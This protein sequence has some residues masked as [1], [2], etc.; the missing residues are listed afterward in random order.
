MRNGNEDQSHP[1][2]HLPEDSEPTYEEWKQLH[3]QSHPYG[4]EYSEPTY[5]EW[6][7][8]TLSFDDTGGLPFGAYL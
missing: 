6:K 4:Q 3:P 5:E 2:W 7:Q 8:L 1:L